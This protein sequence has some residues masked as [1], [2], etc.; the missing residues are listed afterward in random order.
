MDASTFGAVAS[1][2][3]APISLAVILP[4]AANEPVCA[5]CARLGPT[6]CERCEVVVTDGDIA[7][8]TIHA[9]RNDFWEFRAPTDPTYLDQDDDPNWLAWTIEPDGT[10]RVLRRR[11]SG[12]CMFLSASGCS[13]PT[14]I[15]PLICR[16][17]P[18]QFTEAGIDGIAEGCPT[19]LIEPGRTIVDMIGMNLADGVRWHRQLYHELRARAEQSGRTRATSPR[20]PCNQEG[21]AT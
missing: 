2:A 15:R 7:R 21:C 12:A 8:I 11:E 20:V 1:G 14:E 18:Y 6:C 9:G 10:R 3:S 13:L 5:R 4:I 16:L 17:Y 19:Q